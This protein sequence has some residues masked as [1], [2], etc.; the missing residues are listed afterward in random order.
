MVNPWQQWVS[1]DF[2]SGLLHTAMDKLLV[3][4]SFYEHPGS[5]QTALALVKEQATVGLLHCMLYCEIDMCTYKGLQ[6]L[7]ESKKSQVHCEASCP[8]E[9]CIE[10]SNP[11]YD[12]L[13]T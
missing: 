7:D 8:H 12:P 11:C 6:L 9:Q 4:G 2:P 1:Q 3:D 13:C 5:S 10:K